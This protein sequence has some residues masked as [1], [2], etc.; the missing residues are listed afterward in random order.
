MDNTN[1]PVDIK[2]E[3]S[4][5]LLAH[6]LPHHRTA[7]QYH[8]AHQAIAS[9]LFFGLR[10]LVLLLALIG[11]VFLFL[12]IHDEFG[13]RELRVGQ[14]WAGGFVPKSEKHPMNILRKSEAMAL[15]GL[16]M[17]F[18]MSMPALDCWL[19]PSPASK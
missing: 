13:R 11:T 17:V 12:E 16:T 6:G 19:P 10:V 18:K 2:D 4:E 1:Y 5:G 14:D 7:K 8:N 3:Q 9:V 15:S